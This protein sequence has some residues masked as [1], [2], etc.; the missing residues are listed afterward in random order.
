[1]KLRKNDKQY[2]PL[3]AI[4]VGSKLCQV[5]CGFISIYIAFYQYEYMGYLVCTCVHGFHNIECL[6]CLKC[7]VCGVCTCDS[8]GIGQ[9]VFVSW[10]SVRLSM[11]ASSG[12]FQVRLYSCSRNRRPAAFICFTSPMY[13]K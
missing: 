1:M 3:I 11:V 2:C 5:H 12:S 13:C 9:V 6:D 7:G 8:V 4:P 10:K